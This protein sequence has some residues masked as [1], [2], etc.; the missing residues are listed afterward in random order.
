MAWSLSGTGVQAALRVI[1][2][3]ILA[4]LLTPHDF[5][6]VAAALLVVKF[7]NIVSQL[8]IGQAIVQRLELTEQHIRTGFTLSIVTG[9][10]FTTLAWLAAP[11]VASFFAMP[12]LVVV[13]RV[14]GTTFVLKGPAITAQVLLQRA[15]RYRRLAFIEATSFTVG[16]G[17]VGIVMAVVGF[18]VWAL[19][20]AN[21]STVV[22]QS[23]LTLLSQPHA[24]RPLFAPRAARELVWKGGGYTI[25]RLWNAVAVEGDYLVTGHWLGAVA[26]GIYSR[27]YEMLV[28]PAVLFGGVFDKVLFPVMAKV[29]AEPERLATAFRRGL[30]FVAILAMP[31]GIV[32][33][34]LAPEIVSVLLGHRWTAVVL[35]LQIL[36]AGM[37]FRTGYKIS[38]SVLNA[39][40]AVYERAWRQAVYAA[41]VVGGAWI[42]KHWGVSGVAVGVLVAIAM[43]FAL[44]TEVAVREAGLDAKD[45]WAVH[46]PILILTAVITATIAPTASALRHAGAVPIATLAGSLTA[47][48]VVAA[49]A[50]WLAPAATLGPDGRWVL[51][52]VRGYVRAPTVLRWLRRSRG[53]Q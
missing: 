9:A 4:R 20:L 1:V 10:A 17:V 42:G 37:Y 25:G 11:A 44:L 24:V 41:C 22:L 39:S 45:L 33:V 40:G 6:V 43:N 51:A 30:A 13:L 3:L 7:S 14:L 27:A 15:L 28:T 38:E 36:G 47:G 18:G 50:T 53:L 23:V 26:L 8:G 2:T 29:Q 48:L 16:F 5:G 12:Q 21:L 46:R 52:R 31:L 34:L 19:V 49:L 32:V 35:P